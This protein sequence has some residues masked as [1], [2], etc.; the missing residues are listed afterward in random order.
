M[1]VDNRASP[2]GTET[3]VTLI[4]APEGGQEWRYWG[5]PYAGINTVQVRAV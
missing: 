1:P 3:L 4:D 2:S 5:L